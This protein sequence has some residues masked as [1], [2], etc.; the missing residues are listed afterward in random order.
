MRTCPQT[1]CGGDAMA[2]GAGRASIVA[3]SISHAPR[4]GH[5][6]V[7]DAMHHGVLSCTG[8]T[9]LPIVAAIMAE[10]RVH[11]VVVHE[12]DDAE[13]TA[14]SVVSDRDLMSAAGADA[15]DEPSAGSVAGTSVPRIG[16]AESLVR[17]A[18][19]MA[20]HD[21]SHLV[22]VGEANGRP[23]GIL[24]SLDIAVVLAAA[25]DGDHD[26]GA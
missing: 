19:V 12:R 8:D 21:V 10:H 2:A 23:E 18:Q 24:S 9:P 1:T 20:E 16:S 6:R 3:M 13:A 15:I 5:V 14:W 26:R 11:C 22:V 7:S 4:L 17:A 25:R